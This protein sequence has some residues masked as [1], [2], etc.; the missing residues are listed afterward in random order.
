MFGEKEVKE[1]RKE[2]KEEK[3]AEPPKL[4]GGVR[5]I[6]TWPLGCVLLEARPMLVLQASYPFGTEVRHRQRGVS[7]RLSGCAPSAPAR[8]ALALLRK[9]VFHTS[10]CQLTHS[11]IFNH[12]RKK[13]F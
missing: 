12:L 13:F 1:G 10:L 2:R 8:V 7:S 9:E 3:V 11:C 4:A 6:Q 5:A